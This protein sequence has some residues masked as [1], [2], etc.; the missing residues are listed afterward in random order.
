MMESGVSSRLRPTPASAAPVPQQRPPRRWSWSVRRANSSN[1]MSRRVSSTSWPCS[2]LSVAFCSDMTPGWCPE[3]CFLLKRDM[4]VTALW[5]ELL[6][7]GD[8]CRGGGVRAARRVS[9]RTV[10]AAGVHPHGQ[11]HLCH[12]GDSVRICT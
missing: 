9:Q 10:R 8:C 6:V 2:P 1:R 11:L 3:R 7:S 5:Q 4:N 12:W